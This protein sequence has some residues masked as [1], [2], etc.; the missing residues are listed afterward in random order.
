MIDYNLLASRKASESSKMMRLI[1]KAVSVNFGF[2]GKLGDDIKVKEAESS[3]AWPMI[4]AVGLAK[5]YVI[6][7]GA[8][9]IIK[10]A[11]NIESLKAKETAFNRCLDGAIKAQAARMMGRKYNIDDL[12]FA[13]KVGMVI[14]YI[15]LNRN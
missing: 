1:I 3:A 14:N 15:N 13:T 6:G 8:D 2:E 4:I 10:D 11:L 12:R 5:L 7:D 9:D